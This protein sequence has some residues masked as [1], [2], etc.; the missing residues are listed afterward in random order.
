MSSHGL[1]PDHALQLRSGSTPK[2]RRTPSDLYQLGSITDFE[3]CNDV[4]TQLAANAR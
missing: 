2:W 4:L 1:C 3:G